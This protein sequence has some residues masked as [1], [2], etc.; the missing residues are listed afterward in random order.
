M[1]QIRQF[2]FWGKYQQ[3]LEL[4]SAIRDLTADALDGQYGGPAPKKWTKGGTVFEVGDP[5]YVL[6]KCFREAKK[7]R[8]VVSRSCCYLPVWF[9]YLVCLCMNSLY[10]L[11]EGVIL[12]G[13][14][15]AGCYVVQY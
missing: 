6:S 11:F 8:M 9:L 10:C 1:T 13:L 7:K 4:M 2:P 14:D 15:R 3:Y 5:I 12:K